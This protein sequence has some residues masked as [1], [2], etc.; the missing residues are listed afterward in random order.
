MIRKQKKGDPSDIILLLVMIFFLA[1]SFVAVGFVNSKIKETIDT[2][3]LNQSD[4]YSSISRSFKTINE[5]TVQRGF[6]LFFGFLI[7]GILVSSF[8]IKVHPIFIFIY[9]IVLAMAIF[10]AIYLANAYELVVSNAQ[11]AALSS[12]NTMIT[13][14][15][16]NVVKILLGVGALSMVI[17]FSKIF[18]GGGGESPF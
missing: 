4:A 14:V 10:T 3:Q 12:N 18:G 1:I 7:I 8:L 5:V 16:Q 15:M 11:F 17:I 6:V 9:I 2:T 13:W